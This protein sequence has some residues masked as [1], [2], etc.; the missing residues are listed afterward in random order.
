MRMYKALR[1]QS[2][3]TLGMHMR[4]GGTSGGTIECLPVATPPEKLL[5]LMSRP[6]GP[7][8]C[9]CVWRLLMIFM[10]C[11]WVARADA[12]SALSWPSA[13]AATPRDSESKK[14]A[15][16]SRP[17]LFDVFCSWV[18]TRGRAFVISAVIAS[19]VSADTKEPRSKMVAM[20]LLT[21]PSVSGCCLTTTRASSST[22]VAMC[23]AMA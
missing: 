1:V 5:V 19:S 10:S 13:E 21:F 16:G 12:R 7:E 23:G 9:C 8:P 18:H 17:P 15:C 11:A 4:L 2:K 22:L 3:R 6:L 20:G 14:S